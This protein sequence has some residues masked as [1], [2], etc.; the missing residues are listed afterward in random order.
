[1]V[2][3]RQRPKSGPKTIFVGTRPQAYSPNHVLLSGATKLFDGSVIFNKI[4]IKGWFGIIFKRFKSS[5]KKLKINFNFYLILVFNN[6]IKFILT[7]S[8]HLT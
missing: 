4:L 8:S 1:M 2:R 5:F 7:K 6:F 3:M